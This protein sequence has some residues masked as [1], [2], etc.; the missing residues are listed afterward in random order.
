MH[1]GNSGGRLSE[2]WIIPPILLEQLLVFELNQAKNGCSS[3][4]AVIDSG[5][6][7]EMVPFSSFSRNGWPMYEGRPLLGAARDYLEEPFGTER[8]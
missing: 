7:P 2:A 1:I 5:T 6:I 8:N 4:R 3:L